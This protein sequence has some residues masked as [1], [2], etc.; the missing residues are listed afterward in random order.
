MRRRIL[1]SILTVLTITTVVLGVPLIYT[2]WLWVEDITRNDLQ[3]R[4]EQVAAEVIAQERVDG[5]VHDGLD[6][7]TMRALVPEGGKLTIVYPAPHDNAA[8]TDLGVDQ[9]DDPLVESLSMGT[10]GSLRLEVPAGPMHAR[11]EQAVAAVALA[12]LA[13]LGAAFSVA[14]VT[15][16]RVADP[17]RD[18]ANRAAR[19]AMGDFRPD[20]RRHGIAELDRVSDVLDSATV[21]IAGR[22]QREHA[23]VAD[24]SHQLR[25]RLTAV[26]LR[27]DELSTH[28]DPEVVHEAEEAMAQVDRLTDAIDDLVRASRD[29]DAADR[30][31]VPVMAELRGVVAEWAHPFTEE[32]RELRLTGDESLRAPITGSRLREAVA[33]LVDNALMH[34]GGT[35]TV[36]VRTVPTMS[37]RDPL[38]CVEVADE[39]E[40]IR[41][42]LAPHVFD[43]GFS[44]GGST[45]VGLALA[46]A[47]VEADGG[48]LEL[49]RRR[50]ALFAVFL[51]SKMNRSPNA[52]LTEPR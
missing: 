37:A 47:L 22:L 39:G 5:T 21:E 34:G 51:G 26:R 42:E 43:R 3:S 33:V 38:I 23:L 15:A 18:V 16:R 32:G 48:R 6:V 4:L 20:P 49:Q 13:S 50:P 17:L 11:Q 28:A 12:V 36:S 40:G 9:V 45:G 44:A 10:S 24:V 8:R 1:R 41:D 35:C 27:L 14:V 52:T 25:S 2:A 29:E 31:P 7:R 46:R 30:D 19:L